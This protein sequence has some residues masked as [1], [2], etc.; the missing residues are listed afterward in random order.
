MPRLA[1][2]T[3]QSLLGIG[4]TRATSWNL[5]RTIDN[6]NDYN[7]TQYDR[8][9]YSLAMSGNY[10]IA[11]ATGE[12]D[13]DG[14]NSGKAY[15][16]NVTTGALVH[17]LDNPNAYG[18]SA[19]DSFGSSVT[20][21]GNRAIV[22]APS[23]DDASGNSSGKAYIY[24]VTTGALL[25]TLDNPNAYGTS[26]TDTF[27]RDRAVE[28]SG[29]YAIIG[30]PFEDDS[31]G[32]SSGKA[33]IFD[34]TT[35]NLLQTLD[36]PN[37]N[38]PSTSDLF[39]ANVSISG[40][41]AIAGAYG[42]LNSGKAYIFD[43]T[44]GSLVHTLDNPDAD[45]LPAS[46]S[47][48]GAVAISGNYAIV[49]ARF[50]DDSDGSNSGKAYIFNVTTGALIHT[51]DNPNAYGT[52][53]SDYFGSTVKINGNYAIVA[54]NQENDENGLESGKIY[55]FDI[56]TGNLLQTLDNPDADGNAA[57]DRFG[58][59]I[60]T[61]GNYIIVGGYLESDAGGIQSGKMYIYKRS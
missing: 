17:T 29:D 54:A 6:P 59:S 2:L 39:A 4:I 42:E 30:A 7:T 43:V 10:V 13:S 56:T 18:T 28:M 51:L 19:S 34:V 31:D 49:G 35:G 22:S 8:F 16:Y 20:M 9:T 57:S 11:G 32:T 1:S 46:D 41:Y 12:D 25:H 44:T 47:F 60:A 53:G 40:D 33:Y 3:T 58:Y 55:I 38:S 45:G 37:P 5:V 15:I 14:T 27:G 26:D 52:S 50:E 21:S 61:S 24:N 23:E 36:N 48:G